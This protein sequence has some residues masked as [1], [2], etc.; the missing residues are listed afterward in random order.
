M[1]ILHIVYNRVGQGSYWRAFHFGRILSQRGHQVTVMATSPRNRTGIVTRQVEGFRLVETPDLF[2]GSLRSG[3]DAWNTLNR[4]F[5]LRKHSFDLVYAIECRPTV[6]YPALYLHRQRHIPLVLGWS[7]WLGRGG[8]VEERKNPIIRNILRPIE[9]YFEEHFRAE[10]DG[11]T[12]ICSTL[13]KKALALGIPADTIRL[14]PDGSDTERFQAIERQTYRSPLGLSSE[15]LIL[16][17]V[18]SI[19]HQDALLMAQAFDRVADLESRAHLLVAGY[20]PIAI[21]ELSRHP[22]RI[23]QT[24][25]LDDARLQQYLSCCDLFLLPLNNSNANQGRW[26]HKLNDYMALGRPTVATSVGDV[27]PLFNETHIGLL[28]RDQPEEFASQALK[29]LQNPQ[30]RDEMGKKARQVAEERFSWEKLTDQL[31]TLYAESA[32]RFQ[33]SRRN[34]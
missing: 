25:P 22:Q 3:W 26:P 7:D 15:S 6:I 28:S 34:F 9:T 8:S 16:G 18:G 19:F 13:E 10:A 12:A 2:R 1:N 30:L 5:W 23:T 24:G 32:E 21:S 14:I 11:T 17:Y 27:Q 33:K 20:C 29:L 4:L 31:E